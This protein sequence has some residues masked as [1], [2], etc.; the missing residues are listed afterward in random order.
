MFGRTA[1]GMRDRRHEV[2]EQMPTANARANSRGYTLAL[3]VYVCAYGT[4][5]CVYAFLSV[6][7]SA[8]IRDYMPSTAHI[9][10]T[11]DRRW[12]VAYVVTT[13]ARRV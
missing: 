6:Y 1:Y 3:Q 9:V 7:I 10:R 11:H 8:D 13:G 2:C 12:R 4:C 5:M